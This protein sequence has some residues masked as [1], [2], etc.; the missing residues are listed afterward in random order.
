MQ[1]HKSRGAQQTAHENQLNS[2]RG[3][4]AGQII[5]DDSNHFENTTHHG[6]SRLDGPVPDPSRS[7]CCQQACDPKV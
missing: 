6:V 2:D 1:M 5:Q 7:A 4:E 3:D